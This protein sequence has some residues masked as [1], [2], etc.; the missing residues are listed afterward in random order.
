M[1]SGDDFVAEC[2]GALADATPL[3]A[4]RDVVERAVRDGVGGLAE[5]PGIRV[6]WCDPSLTVAHVVI[7]AGAPKSLPHD[8]RM[9]AVIG[10]AG[11]CEDN[12]FFRRSAD[13]LEASG[14][15][16]VEAGEVLS[17]GPETIHAVGNPLAHTSTSG[18]HVYGGDLVNTPRS[19]WTEPNWHEEPYDARRATGTHFATP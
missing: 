8:H 2:L 14:G 11:G 12:E 9:W 15:R 10:I 7:P 1:L 18:L 4:I 17:L 3:L 6:L 16:V 5:E 19:M 13:S